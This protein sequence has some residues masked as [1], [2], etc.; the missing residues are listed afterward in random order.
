MAQWHR[1]GFVDLTNG[2]TAAVG[3]DSGWSLAGVEAGDLFLAP[4]QQ[5]YEVASVE[6]DLA[7]TLASAYQ[8]ANIAGA[9][10]AIIRVFNYTTPAS[11]AARI[12][13]LLL[14][15]EQRE[16]EQAAWLAGAADGGSTLVANTCLL[17]GAD[18][19]AYLGGQENESDCL[20]A[21]GTWYATETPLTDG[22]YLL[23]NASG[24][25]RL[26]K[27]PAKIMAEY[28]AFIASNTL[29]GAT[30]NGGSVVDSTLTNVNLQSGQVGSKTVA[31]VEATVDEVIA[32]GVQLDAL[33]V[34]IAAL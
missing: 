7:L 24:L 14:R 1:N 12:S 20:T 28:D 32:L 34:T 6:S 31:D 30:L 10:Y 25:S 21:G 4:D 27:S 13:Q 26:I 17:V 3:T 23:T 2:S 11:L 18:G 8:G 22:R 9:N 33:A 15:W 29:S 16:A 19:V 5:L